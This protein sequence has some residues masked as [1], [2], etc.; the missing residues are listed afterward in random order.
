MDFSSELITQFVSSVDPLIAEVKETV[1]SLP[2]DFPPAHIHMGMLK[3]YVLG[4]KADVDKML[5]ELS[6]NIKVNEKKLGQL[7]KCIQFYEA[8]QA[9]L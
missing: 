2:D 9:E 6:D 8:Q 7:K 4:M 1:E 5:K 3:E